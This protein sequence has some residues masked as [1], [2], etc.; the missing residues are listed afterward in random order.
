LAH[1]PRS[2]GEALTPL[3]RPR[4]LL[5]SHGDLERLLHVDDREPIPPDGLSIDLDL[6]VGLADDAL[7]EHG[8]AAHSG[9]LAE[10]LL[11][12]DAEALDRLEIRP[13][14]LHAHGRA[15]PALE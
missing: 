5:A 6:E 10:D 1:I 15:H 11:D 2:H 14:D 7:G 9:H 3:D 13:V 8:V 4:E 12:G